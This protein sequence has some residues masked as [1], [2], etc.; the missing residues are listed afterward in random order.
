MAIAGALGA[1][2]TTHVPL[3]D[4]HRA[5]ATLPADSLAWRDSPYAEPL[6][7]S[8]ESALRDRAGFVVRSLSIPSAADPEAAIEFE[9]YDVDGDERRPVIVLLP[10]FNGSLAIQRFF[11]RYFANQ[12]WGAVVVV[13]GH[14]PLQTLVD[15]EETAQ[16]SLADY[17]RVLDWVEGE[18]ELDSSR[19]G[20]FG[21][22][23]GAMDAIVL[24][25]LDRRIDSL[26]VAMAG[27]DLAYLVQSTSYR[28]VVRGMEELADRAGTSV[29]AL[30][31]KLGDEMETQPMRLA[32]YIDPERV[33]MIVTRT[34]AIVPFEAQQRLRASLGSPETLYLA[35]GHRPSVLLF[36]KVRSTAFE[37]FARQFGVHTG[38]ADPGA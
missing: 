16:R 38:L 34:D 6:A 2:C 37:F 9:Y 19:M 13:R 35:T 28:P 26:V 21:V 11:A 4:E 32:R 29:E 25:A 15:P 5:A 3:D 30:A 1:A 17:R 12:G 33:L 23:L 22:S 24:S 14:D 27:G 36:P 10:I 31:A 7:V 20:V 8:D 18:T